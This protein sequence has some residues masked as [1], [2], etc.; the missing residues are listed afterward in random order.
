M[1]NFERHDFISS[2]SIASNKIVELSKQLR[3][4]NSEIESLKSKYAK[5]ELE[6]LHL[7][8][9]EKPEEKSLVNYSI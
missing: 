2:A 8:K 9:Q 4:K 7:N 5:L 3:E 1:N 6:F